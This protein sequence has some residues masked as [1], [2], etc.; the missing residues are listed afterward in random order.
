MNKQL[1]LEDIHLSVVV[2]AFNEEKRIGSTLPAIFEYLDKTAY[3]YELIVVDD[4]S[5]DRTKDVVR[6][7]IDGVE[8]ARLISY[9]PNRGKGYAVRCGILG[10]KG[11]NILFTDADLSTPIQEVEKFFP[12]LDKGYDIVIASKRLV[13]SKVEVF[14]PFY[15][16]ESAKIFNFIRYAI[17]GVDYA[18]TQ[19]GFKLF[20]GRVARD[21]FGRLTIE[22]YM[23]DSE[24]LYLAEKLGYR[25]KEMP[26]RWRDVPG[27]T[28]NIT[29][30]G[31]HMLRDLV[32][33]RINHRKLQQN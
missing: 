29:R 26:V 31:T 8:G 14:Q 23:F 18:D 17:L 33:I 1:V 28:L 10:S 5:K 12:L 2:P 27:S 13:D 20:K 6:S 24:T 15:R 11:K 9:F 25:V 16:R 7:L 32:R 19:C 4:G 22:R 21:L 3:R 30:E